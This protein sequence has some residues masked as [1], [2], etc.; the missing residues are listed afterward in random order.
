MDVKDKELVALVRSMLEDSF[1]IKHR[2]AERHDG[3]QA[4]QK[5]YSLTP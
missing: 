1:V 5:S 2:R 3:M 4:P